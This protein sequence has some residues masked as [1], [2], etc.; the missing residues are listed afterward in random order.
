MN[1]YVVVVLSR[2][3]NRG[4]SNNNIN[5]KPLGWSLS[6]MSGFVVVVQT[7]SNNKTYYINNF[8]EKGMV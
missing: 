1:R 6:G 4:R 2:S 7:C 8:A 3:S 5:K